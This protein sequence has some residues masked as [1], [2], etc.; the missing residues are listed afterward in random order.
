MFKYN[1][2][3]AA[4]LLSLNVACEDPYGP[5][6]PGTGEGGVQ[7]AAATLVTIDE[8]GAYET[9][10]KPQ[11]GWTGD[12]SRTSIVPVSFSRTMDMEVKIAHIRININPIIPGTKL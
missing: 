4:L 6:P 2:M 11:I 8:N 9:F 7:D 12:T 3:A 10:F 1:V 5:E